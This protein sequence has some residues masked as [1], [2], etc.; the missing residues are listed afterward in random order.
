MARRGPVP[1]LEI[2]AEVPSTQ[3]ALIEAVTADPDGWPDMSVLAADN[4]SAGLGRAGRQWETAPRSSVTASILLRPAGVDPTRWSWLP[5]MGG[6][7]AVRAVRKV[8]RLPAGL[9]WPNDV[10]VEVP[11]ADE[12]PGWGRLRK[13]GGVLVQLVPDPAGGPV[14]L[15]AVL[16]VGINVSQTAEELPVAWAGSLA[17][18]GAANVDRSVLLTSVLRSITKRHQLWCESGGAVQSTGIAQL[19]RDVCVTIGSRVRV[20]LPSGETFT[21]EADGLDLAGH[22]IVRTDAGAVRTVV[23]GDVLSVRSGD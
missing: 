15:G 6:L 21:G 8:T 5:L 12:V 17:T 2:A 3:T 10:V 18:V 20:E 16:G 11:D 19:V 22:L 23:A 9:K 7:A 14:P 13:L 1:R 4:Q